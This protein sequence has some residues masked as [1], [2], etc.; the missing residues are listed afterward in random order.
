MVNNAGILR[1][2]QLVNETLEQWQQVISV[3]QTGVFLGM[4]AAA[5]AMIAAGTG[6]SIINISSLA[7]LRGRPGRCPTA[8]PSGRS[9][10]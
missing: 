5:K 3:N 8:P 10:G 7:G 9:G 4:R 1:H 2:N 6:G